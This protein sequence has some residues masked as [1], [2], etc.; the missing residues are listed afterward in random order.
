M[1]RIFLDTSALVKRYHPE[2]G[3]DCV[4]AIFEDRNHSL[5]TSRLT[6]TEL[7]SAMM[8]RLRSGEIDLA[9]IEAIRAHV[10]MEVRQRR[11]LVMAVSPFHFMEAGRI[12]MTLGQQASIRTLDAI[13]LACARDVRR[14]GMVDTLMTADE[15]LLVVATIDGFTVLNPE[16]A[17]D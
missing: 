10:L 5:V 7:Q 3:S 8:R 2:L 12:L 13:Q 15:R 9:T 4:N 14:R 1:T 6:I 16:S 17:R 11:I